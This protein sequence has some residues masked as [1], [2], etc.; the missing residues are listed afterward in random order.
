MAV[1]TLKPLAVI[2]SAAFRAPAQTATK[3]MALPA[4]VIQSKA[5]MSFVSK[6]ALTFL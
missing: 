4:Q 3:E 6:V 1:A 2:Q 5:L